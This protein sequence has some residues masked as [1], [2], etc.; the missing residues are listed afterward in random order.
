MRNRKNKSKLLQ[1]YRRLYAHFGPQRWWPSETLFEM[2]VG[3]V[4][5]QN[6]A[7][8]NVEKAIHN[9]REKDL[10]DP[11]RIAS[12]NMRKLR[13]AIRPSGF[14]N[15]KAKRLKEV[16]GFLIR[17]CNGKIGELRGIDKGIL[18]R[19]LLEIYGIGPET[20]DSILLYALRKPV[21]VV[22][23]YTRRLL[24]RHR[25]IGEAATYDQ[26]QAL[27]MDNIPRRAGLFNEYHALIVKT[28]KEY[29][30]KKRGLCHACPLLRY[31]GHMR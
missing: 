23:S 25:L 20:A 7:W 10:L 2:I 27:F 13:L 8:A 28:G 24:F 29:C 19:R 26:I 18:R 15:E 9:L 11:Q 16:T 3:A 5:T 17:S 30:R 14:Y 31:N 22:D 12:V 1:I 6:T 4:L 21:F